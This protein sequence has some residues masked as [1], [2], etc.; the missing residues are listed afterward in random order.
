VI[1]SAWRA[2]NTRRVA[3]R[4]C[5]R[6]T[7]C[8]ANVAPIVNRLDR[9]LAIHSTRTLSIAPVVSTATPRTSIAPC[10]LEPGNGSAEHR[11]GAL[12]ITA[13][14]TAPGRRPALQVTVQ[15]KPAENRGRA[16][17]M[18]SLGTLRGSSTA[19]W[20]HE[21]ATWSPRNFPAWKTCP[22]IAMICP[23]SS[24]LSDRCRM[25]ASPNSDRPTMKTRSAAA[26]PLP[27]ADGTKMVWHRAGN[28]C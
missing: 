8:A 21:P 17:R 20:G 9:G 25:R 22:L 3:N 11:L 10:A 26:A 28:W 12:I 2:G 5:R 6:L 13:I 24:Q 1:K 15:G 14:R 7:V 18:R 27:Q 4:R 19:H 23:V 16:G